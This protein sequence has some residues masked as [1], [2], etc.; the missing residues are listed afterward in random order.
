MNSCV[1]EVI[2]AYTV[3]FI[4]LLMTHHQAMNNHSTPYPENV[5]ILAWIL[6]TSFI[7]TASICV[8]NEYYAIPTSYVICVTCLV[9]IY[10]L[11]F[12]KLI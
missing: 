2:V 9:Y 7:S 3:F 8:M 10:I 11:L 5:K 4:V 12:R 1:V 6:I